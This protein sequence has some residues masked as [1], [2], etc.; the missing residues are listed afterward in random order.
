ML[1]ALSSAGLVLLSASGL[2]MLATVLPAL[3]V[4]DESGEAITEDGSGEI[5]TED[6]A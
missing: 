3:A 1:P 4:T 2:P 5:I 6:V